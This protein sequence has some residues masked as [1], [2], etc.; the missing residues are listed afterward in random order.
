MTASGGAAVNALYRLR[1]LCA[2]VVRAWRNRGC[3]RLDEVRRA[4]IEAEVATWPASAPF[5]T[6]ELLRIRAA[7]RDDPAGYAAVRAY[8]EWAVRNAAW[9]MSAEATMRLSADQAVDA[10]QKQLLELRREDEKEGVRT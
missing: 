8:N 5:T 2:R 3:S 4:A 6:E 10:L 1:L 7:L 9:L